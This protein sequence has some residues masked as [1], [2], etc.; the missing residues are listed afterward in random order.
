MFDRDQLIELGCGGI[1]A[2]NGGS[3]EPP[4]MVKLTYRP[5]GATAHLALVGK[6]IM[7]DSG[8]ISLK[9]GDAVHATMKN[10]MSG[11]GDV[12]AAMLHLRDTGLPGD[13]HRLPD[14]HR[15]HAVRDGRPSSA[16]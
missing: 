16:T 12:L 1:I 4:R 3:D 9:P 7:Y 10:D 15:Q 11:A 8:G 2:V 6:G 13:R 14:V 5:D